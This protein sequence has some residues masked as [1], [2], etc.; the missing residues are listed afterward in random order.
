MP[1]CTDCGTE[2]GAEVSYCPECGHEVGSDGVGSAKGGSGSADDAGSAAEAV[3]SAA[4]DTETG[5]ETITLGITDSET[6][7]DRRVYRVSNL[8]YTRLIT[9]SLT[10]F[11]KALIVGVPL[12]VTVAAY[13]ITGEP[14][15]VA[16]LIL[17]P[18]GWWY[19]RPTN[20][21]DVATLTEVD[22]LA[23]EDTRRLESQIG[24]R[25]P[26]AIRV[27]G[28]IETPLLSRSYLYRFHPD[29]VVSVERVPGVLLDSLL[30]AL[31]VFAGVVYVPIASFDGNVVVGMALIAAGGVI[32]LGYWFGDRL[33]RGSGA[34]D[35]Y[36]PVLLGA[37]VVLAVAAVVTEQVV[38]PIAAWLLPVI[39]FGGLLLGV[40][41]RLK[42]RLSNGETREEQMTADDI[43]RIM[44]E[45]ES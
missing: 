38:V 4:G 19:L 45:F 13:R 17:A 23:A 11:A 22:Y 31:V 27:E 40:G 14:N 37:V 28:S 21:L 30:P 41:D 29:N 15:A 8:V 3:D 43:V 12:A 24:D 2:I 7:S 20:G 39:V 25:I 1:Y 34:D 26:D 35:V 18:I 5:D 9:A 33:C 10:L 6:G 44:S 42:I 36:I 32:A 16:W